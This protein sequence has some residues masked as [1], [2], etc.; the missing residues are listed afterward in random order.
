MHTIAFLEASPL[1]TASAN[2]RSNC[3]DTSLAY[4]LYYHQ[5]WLSVTGYVES[6]DELEALILKYFDCQVDWSNARSGLAGQFWKEIAT[7]PNGIRICKNWIDGLVYQVRVE[8]SGTPLT[9]IE[10]HE[11]W[12]LSKDIHALGLRCTRFDWAIDDYSRTLSLSD[13]RFAYETGSYGRCRSMQM[14][15]SG[16]AGQAPIVTGFSCGSRQSDKYIR[17]YDK[18]IESRGSANYGD[19]IRYEVEFKGDYAER[20]FEEFV[21]A[22]T[23]EQAFDIASKYAIGCIDFIDRTNPHLDLCPVAP[24]W[25]SF[26]AAVGGKKRMAVPRVRRTVDKIIHFVEKQVV[27]SLALLQV[28]MGEVWFDQ[29]VID[30]VSGAK[31]KFGRREKDFVD[32]HNRSAIK[33]DCV[34]S[35]Y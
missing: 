35:I 12:Q 18:E 9:E 8:I 13:I 21:F 31:K 1:P 16:A 3:P 27:K 20:L 29:T 11:A 25:Q 10:A 19:S 28:C 30:W 5:D 26:V 32:Y 7:A 33:Y 22:A 2:R 4:D 34:P 6:L 15:S 14:Y 17:I 24:W 23:V